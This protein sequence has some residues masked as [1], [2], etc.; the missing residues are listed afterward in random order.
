MALSKGYEL[1]E[2]L[3][4]GRSGWVY[5]AKHIES[6][7]IVAI[8]VMMMRSTD[9]DRLRLA[10]RECT[11]NASIKHPSCVRVITFYSEALTQEIHSESEGSDLDSEG[12][13]GNINSETSN[14]DA[15]NLSPGLNEHKESEPLLPATSTTAQSTQSSTS[16]NSI[17]NGN[18]TN[19]LAYGLQV[20]LVMQ[21]SGV[22]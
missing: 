17:S 14:F 2:R 13:D 15:I 10:Y 8:K 18:N 16:E 3:G 11:M 9:A 22:E 19:R 5:R 20:H 1:L 6:Q 12:D 4:Q 21:G 7:R